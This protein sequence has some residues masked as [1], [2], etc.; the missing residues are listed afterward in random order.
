MLAFNRSR[1]VS[2]WAKV[3]GLG[4]RRGVL[5]AC[6]L[7][8]LAGGC[9]WNSKKLNGQGVSLYHQGN[10]EGAQESFTQALSH[11]SNNANIYYNLARVHHQ[12]GIQTNDHREIE[13]AEDY[14]NQALDHDPNH[15]DCYRALAVLLVEDG[16]SEKAFT[17]L[18]RWADRSPKLADPKIELA[19]L[20]EEFN[21][22]DIAKEKLLAA[23]AVDP[24]NARAL[25]AL[26]SIHERQG[27]HSQA[28][29]DYRRSLWHDRQQPEVAARVAELQAAGTRSN[30]KSI[31]TPA[32]RLSSPQ[33]STFR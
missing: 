16:R 14:Y 17:L 21:E 6:C 11:D 22:M 31:S 12:R 24:K 27:D 7:C 20:Y 33:S 30:S 4:C 15:R 26:G 10:L 5:A 13:K 29:A 23:V 9:G 1:T 28:L 25:A 18:E 32:S 3:F 8:L 2:P 19:R